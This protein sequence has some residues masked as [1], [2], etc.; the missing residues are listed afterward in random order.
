MVTAA[1]SFAFSRATRLGLLFAIPTLL[2]LLV[3]NRTSLPHSALPRGPENVAAGEDTSHGGGDAVRR[4]TLLLA[5]DERLAP[6]AQPSVSTASSVAAA[7]GDMGEERGAIIAGSAAAGVLPAVASSGEGESVGARVDGS[8]DVA[9]GRAEGEAEA[10]NAG[11]QQQQ[12]AQQ[13]KRQRSE[14]PARS[15]SRRDRLGIRSGRSTGA[16]PATHHSNHTATTGSSSRSSGHGTE[17]SRSRWRGMSSAEGGEEE[18]RGRRIFILDLPARFNHD[19]LALCPNVCPPSAHLHLAA[20]HGMGLPIPAAASPV[21]DVR[22]SSTGFEVPAS[23]SSFTRTKRRDRWGT[24]RRRDRRKE[25]S[26][27]SWS[28]SHS[29]KTLA[30]ATDAE[31]SDILTVS[32]GS[33]AESADTTTDSSNT[34]TESADSTAELADP[35]K[36]T[37]EVDI[38]G[39]GWYTTS[40]FALERLFHVR[41]QQYP[42]LTPHRMAAQLVYV[43]YYPGYDVK[44][45]LSSAP[46]C[47]VTDAL[48][49]AALDVAFAAHG[50]GAGGGGGSGGGGGDGDAGGDSGSVATAAASG[51]S[52]GVGGGDAVSVSPPLLLLLGHIAME[53]FRFPYQTCPGP[54]SALLR[55]PRLVRQGNAVIVGIEAY[56]EGVP[57]TSVPYPSYFHPRTKGELDEWRSKVMGVEWEEGEWEGERGV[58]E[59]EEGVGGEEDGEEGLGR[60]GEV[61]EVVRTLERKLGEEEGDDD[62]DGD[63]GSEGDQVEEIWK[64][65][66]N[67]V[68]GEKESTGGKKIGE[69]KLGE[70]GNDGEEEGSDLEEAEEKE[71]VKGTEEKR[72]VEEEGGEGGDGDEDA[73]EEATHGEKGRDRQRGDE[74]EGA[75]ERDKEEEEVEDVVRQVWEKLQRQVLGD[76]DEGVGETERQEKEEEEKDKGEEQEKDKGEE[77]EKNKREEEEEEKDAG[78]EDEEEGVGEGEKK[79]RGLEGESKVKEVKGEGEEEDEDEDG[80]KHAWLK[81]QREVLG[82]TDAD[83]VG[84]SL[85]GKERG[86]AEEADEERGKEEG[87]EEGGEG[88]GEDEDEVKQMGEEEGEDDRDVKE[89]VSAREQ[90]GEGKAAE[91]SSGDKRAGQGEEG[92]AEGE[93]GE[94]KEGEGEEGEEEEDEEEEVESRERKASSGKKTAASAGP[95]LQH[96]GKV[97]RRALGGEGGGRWEKGGGSEVQRKDGRGGLKE[98]G[99]GDMGAESGARRSDVISQRGGAEPAAVA[100]AALRDKLMAECDAAGRQCKFL[101]CAIQCEDPTGEPSNNKNHHQHQQQQQQ[102][103]QVR[104]GQQQQVR[105]GEC[106]GAGVEVAAA[107]APNPVYLCDYPR[108]VMRTHL[109]SHFCLQPWGDSPTR[110]SLFDAMLAG[111]IPVVFSDWSVQRQFPWHLPVH[112]G[113]RIGFEVGA[114]GDVVP[115][116][117]SASPSSHARSSR[118]P[119]NTPF[120]VF[121]PAEAILNGSADLVAI[122]S[123]FPP[124]KVARMRHRI[125]QLLP[126]LL[127]RRTGEEDGVVRRVIKSDVVESTGQKEEE[128]LLWGNKRRAGWNEL[129]NV[130]TGNDDTFKDAFDVIIERALSHALELAWAGGPLV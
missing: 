104:H 107:V 59:K 1:T 19:L 126:R 7:A 130:D 81:L 117:S 127:Y 65:L 106:P 96:R 82:D 28:Y 100:G 120:Y 62:G 3:A 38:G 5:G 13:M 49:L 35:H 41:L 83:G 112:E 71:T 84:E 102:Q 37:N 61:E 78:D 70:E 16:S 51:S 110:R 27:G 44:R 108:I 64:K 87:E 122:L 92:V 125:M 76:T 88:E 46:N 113:E 29:R 97:E 42:C 58:G 33:S 67:Q 72:K 103:Q 105:H 98:R 48:G 77:E 17:Q 9:H 119:S 53:F 34:S 23:S 99:V 52:G 2:L 73:G 66:K 75:T 116:P 32:A 26:R 121:V 18:C 36:P 111:C 12:D 93:G 55:D 86:G 25:S 60:G 79:R 129:V 74:E 63:G 89:R 15:S 45:H 10:G 118:S 14:S 47:S 30:T 91:G 114:S 43:P 56:P 11:S 115:L 57:V 68:Y 22:R 24:R 21:R 124:Y 6:P 20:C 109:A 4:E 128:K 69:E 94:G 101:D 85:D 95:F 40:Q 90:A 8:L 31:S 80:V 54:G 50:S 39:P 123:S